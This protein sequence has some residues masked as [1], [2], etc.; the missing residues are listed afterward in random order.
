MRSD[1]MILRTMQLMTGKYNVICF[2]RMSISPGSLPIKG[3]RTPKCI[4]RPTMIKRIPA[5]MNN[6][7]HEEIIQL[8]S[9]IYFE[10]VRSHAGSVRFQWSTLYF[11][12]ISRVLSIGSASTVRPLYP[13]TDWAMNIEL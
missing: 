1:R 11:L 6:L 12:Q 4:N 3:I 13:R 7:P 8:D 2:F 5:T 10:P 9:R